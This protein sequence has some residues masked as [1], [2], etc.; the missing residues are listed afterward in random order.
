MYSAGRLERK[1]RCSFSAV[2]GGA[3]AT[4]MA[5]RETAR[6]RASKF[7]VALYLPLAPVEAQQQN[8]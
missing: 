2:E 1:C 5:N 7:S 4:G 3:A 8:N 6:A